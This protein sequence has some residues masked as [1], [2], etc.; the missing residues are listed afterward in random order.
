VQL[1]LFTSSALESEEAQ[2]PVCNVSA[3]RNDA[4]NGELPCNH[5][6]HR[7]G[8]N[9]NTGLPFLGAI[10]RFIVNDPQSGLD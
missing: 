4:S 1:V 8:A 7:H 10:E 2:Q 3:A 5:C 6:N 9:P